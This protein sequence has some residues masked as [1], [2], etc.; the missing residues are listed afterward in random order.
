MG[1]AVD[2]RA[3]ALAEQ[4]DD[5]QRAL[6]VELAEPPEDRRHVIGELVDADTMNCARREAISGSWGL[7]RIPDGVRSHAS[8]RP[9]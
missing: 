7:L 1:V 4:R 8:S 5:V 9:W 6:R 3:L 2:E